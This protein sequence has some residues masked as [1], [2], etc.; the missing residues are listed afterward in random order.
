MIVKSLSR[1]KQKRDPFYRLVKYVAKDT[2]DDD[3][4][5]C[6]NINTADLSDYRAIAN[7][8]KENVS[9]CKRQVKN[10]VLVYHDFLS[11]HPDDYEKLN[12]EILRDLALKWLEIR[13]VIDVDH[14]SDEKGRVTSVVT[15]G[16]LVFGN[17]HDESQP[18]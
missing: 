7:E 15:G 14:I 8:F 12:P 13:K 17:I 2:S 4:L 11:M 9:L 16:C 1:K 5:M 6:F 3:D 10:S 18:G